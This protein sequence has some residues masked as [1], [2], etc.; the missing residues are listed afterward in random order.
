MITNLM[1]LSITLLA[2]SC[3]FGVLTHVFL[4]LWV[5]RD[6]KNNCADAALWTVIT[7]FLSL[8]GLILYYAVGRKQN[9]TKC[10]K[11]FSGVH[12]EAQYC[13]S[14]GT[15]LTKETII[16]YSIYAAGYRKRTVTPMK[17][18]FA[19]SL[20]LCFVFAG[21]GGGMMG[22]AAAQSDMPSWIDQYEKKVE[23]YLNSEQ[24]TEKKTPFTKSSWE[25]SLDKGA[26]TKANKTII[27]HNRKPEKLYVDYGI[28]MGKVSITIQQGDTKSAYVLAGNGTNE[29]ID[30]SDFKDGNIAISLSTADAKDADMEFMW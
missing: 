2:L 3:V 27:I 9:K 18:W 4:C 23:P 6:A 26:A 8:I 25:V 20:A 1:L 12:P 21:V 11:C 14:C 29:T 5:Y 10:P 17:V 28:D 30:L 22:Y 7:L 16:G 13:Q 19:I 24:E 15:A